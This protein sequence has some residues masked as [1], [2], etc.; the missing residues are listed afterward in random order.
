M[1]PAKPVFSPVAPLSAA[2]LWVRACELFPGPDSGPLRVSWIRA[3]RL[4][5][6]T[7]RGW[8]LDRGTP[9]PRWGHGYTS[10]P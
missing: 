3:V 6:Q 5:R 1:T 10:N 9:P 7:R 8:V 2:G 4:V